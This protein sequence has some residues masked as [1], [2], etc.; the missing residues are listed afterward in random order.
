MGDDVHDTLCIITGSAKG[1]GKE[2]AERLLKKGSKV[3]I[4]DLN[5]TLGNKTTKDLQE[6]YG[7]GAVT[8]CK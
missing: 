4:S 3:C 7:P 5:E 6:K 2:F 8:F 1:L